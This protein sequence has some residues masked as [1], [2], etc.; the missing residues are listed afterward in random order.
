MR[1]DSFVGCAAVLA[2]AK[3]GLPVET[4]V[5]SAGMTVKLG[6]SAGTAVKLR[7]AVKLR[8]PLAG[9]AASFAAHPALLAGRSASFAVRSAC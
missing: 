5:T 6:S 9:T 3:I 1:I 8:S 2:A 4:A 7:L